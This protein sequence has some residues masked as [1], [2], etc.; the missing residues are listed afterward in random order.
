MARKKQPAP[1]LGSDARSEALRAQPKEALVALLEELAA[2][3]PEVEARLERLAVRD[4]H[5]ELAAG[6]RS[7]LQGWRQSTHFLG[8]SG[9]SGFGRE[10]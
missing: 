8:R 1:V 10:L 3:H 5:A 7:R 4:D 6:F 2:R 9:A